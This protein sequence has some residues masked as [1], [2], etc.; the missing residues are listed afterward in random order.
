LTAIAVVLSDSGAVAVNPNHSTG[1]LLFDDGHGDTMPYRLYVP[2]GYDAP[3]VKLP[4]IMYLHGAG[5]CGTDNNLPSEEAQVDDLYSYTQGNGYPYA[6]GSGGAQYKAFL[7]IPQT[8]SNWGWDDV[9]QDLTMDILHQIT[10]TYQV[11]TSRLYLTGVSMGGFGTFNTLAAYP[12]T[13][14]AGAPLSGGG[15]PGDGPVLKN[16]PIWAFHCADD[17]VVPV[18]C[19][20]AMVNA[21]AAAG[22]TLVEYTRPNTGGHMNGSWYTFY[23]GF[24]YENSHDQTLYQW[25]F[26]QSVPEPSSLSLGLGAAAFV[27]IGGAIRRASRARAKKEH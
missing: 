24:S 3:G 21:I 26:S 16:I 13:F 11:D 5:V 1:D 20:D 6:P 19:T 17:Q 4:L 10:S 15:D 18:Q 25:M 7:L 12:T 27:L 8:T 9:G 14:A 2:P 22:G 23:N